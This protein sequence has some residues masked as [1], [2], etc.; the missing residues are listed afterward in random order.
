MNPLQIF[1]ILLRSADEQKM[2]SKRLERLRT[3]PHRLPYRKKQHFLANG[4]FLKSSRKLD[5][6]KIGKGWSKVDISG[7]EREESKNAIFVQRPLWMIPR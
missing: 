5:I 2:E 7:H 4:I 6:P 3:F 1:H